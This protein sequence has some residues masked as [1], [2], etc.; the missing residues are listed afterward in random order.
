MRSEFPAE[1]AVER[2]PAAAADQKKQR[3]DADQHRI[4]A[5]AIGVKETASVRGDPN[6]IDH[7]G[8]DNVRVGALQRRVASV[9]DKEDP[10]ARARQDRTSV[11]KPS[12]RSRGTWESQN[13]KNT[14]S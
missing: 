7:E 3:D 11:Q 6:R 4:F 10:P 9:V 14:T 1:R 13:E 2:E 5:T 8:A 12:T